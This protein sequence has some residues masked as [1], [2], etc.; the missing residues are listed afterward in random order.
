MEISEIVSDRMHQLKSAFP[1]DFFNHCFAIKANTLR[2]VL[3]IALETGF[4]GAEC[5]SIGE[6][7]H[8][9]NMGFEPHKIVYD[10]PVKSKVSVTWCDIPTAPPQAICTKIPLRMLY[11]VGSSSE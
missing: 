8:S 10:S 2:G 6:V 7:I 1:E 3:K 11:V 4:M 5:A 9:H